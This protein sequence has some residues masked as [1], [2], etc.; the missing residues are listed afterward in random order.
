M[1]IITRLALENNKKNKSRSILIMLTVF[2]TTVLLSAIATFGYANIRYQKINAEK[3][4]G[5]YHGSYHSVTED[6]IIEMEKHSQFAELGKAGAAG[7]VQGE[8]RLSLMWVS[9]QV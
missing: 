3:F 5:R 2:F 9:S 1:N 7:E 8:S 4:Y 6:Q